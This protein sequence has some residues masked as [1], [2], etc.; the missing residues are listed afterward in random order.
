MAVLAGFAAI[1]VF[2]FLICS[3]S[4][5][6][7]RVPLSSGTEL[8]VLDAQVR[9][10]F[11]DSG[12]LD[13]KRRLRQF[14]L[15]RW[16]SKAGPEPSSLWLSVAEF[17]LA[18]GTFVPPTFK[19]PAIRFDDGRK[20]TGKLWHTESNICRIEFA[21]YP[22]ADS[23]LTVELQASNETVR[24]RLRNPERMRSARWK[25]LA[26]PQTNDLFQTRWVLEKNRPGNDLYPFRV[27][28]YALGQDSK[29]WMTWR[30]RFIDELGNWTDLETRGAE[31]RAPSVPMTGACLKI[32]AH[33]TEYISAGMM[34][35][36]EPGMSKELIPARRALELGLN[37]I[38]LMGEGE[39]LLGDGRIIQALGMKQT[40]SQLE[41]KG[42]NSTGAISVKCTKPSLLLL[43]NEPPNGA[44][45][46]ARLRER[47]GDERR[48]K[49]FHARKPLMETNDHG[50]RMV[51][52]LLPLD[53]ATDRTKL[54]AE[55]IVYHP[56]AEF[57]VASSVFRKTRN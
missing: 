26:F 36:P 11:S 6:A 38:Y 39:Y 35:V 24:F 27:R 31:V 8:R 42:R 41:F 7:G 10:S 55:V 46:S 51:A 45:M 3:K 53:I 54:E 40:K 47:G 21:V 15:R 13:W 28:S 22:R 5:N 16:I 50:P 37:R 57:F 14:F 17:D 52:R 20:T 32:M 25:A 33:G 1:G 23:E 44:Q 43:F 19:N 4:S 48:Q 18:G 34:A 56:A 30:A 49:M 2:G 12:E 29:K 9:A